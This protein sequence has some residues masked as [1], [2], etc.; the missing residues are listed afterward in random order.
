VESA[1]FRK[2]R[3]EGERGTAD[4][5]KWWR[6]MAGDV[7]ALLSFGESF[8][9]MDGE[10]REGKGAVGDEYFG[11]LERAGVNIILNSMFPKVVLRVVGRFWGALGQILDANRVIIEKG[12]VA[13]QNLRDEGRGRQ[14]LFSNMLAL[15]DKAR[16]GDEDAKWLTDDAIRSEAAGFLLAGS[17]TTGMALTYMV[18]AVL[19]RPDL[20][21]RMEAEVATL[22]PEFTD[23]DVEKLPLL[24]NVLDEVLRLYNPGSGNI[25]RQV[26]EQGVTWLGYFIPGGTDISTQQWTMVRDDS[27]F[28]D[29]EHF[30]ETRFEHPTEKQRRVAQPFGLGSRS[31]IGIHLAKMEMRLATALF[32]RECRG[33]MI[34]KD[35]SEDMMTQLMK[36]FTY[37]KGNKCNITLVDGLVQA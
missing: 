23:K 25:I 15:A 16:E 35:M 17:D 2:I 31:C 30:D 5:C 19:R 6:L 7:I 32:F 36:F 14:N 28:P 33:A 8:E 4:V 3:E 21:R 1:N 37:A 9:L 29:A 27:L 24:N 34:S 12:T 18:W 11:A 10:K 13:V 22:D 20:R 26:P